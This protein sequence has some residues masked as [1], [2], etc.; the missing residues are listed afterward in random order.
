MKSLSSCFSL[1]LSQPG[2]KCFILSH[3]RRLT[4]CVLSIKQNFVADGHLLLENYENKETGHRGSSYVPSFRLCVALYS[5]NR[6]FGISKTFNSHE[7]SLG[8]CLLTKQILNLSQNCSTIANVNTLFP[9]ISPFSPHQPHNLFELFE[10]PLSFT[11]DE[12]ELDQR[13]KQF[14]KVLHPDNYIG[15]NTNVEVKIVTDL[16][17]AINHAYQV[18][19][20]FEQFCFHLLNFHADIKIPG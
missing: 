5:T 12:K 14:Q 19:C 17:S 6:H 20:C 9:A 18:C 10:F 11:V 2:Q 15:S 13:Y 16:S 3:L 1:I 8:D 7:K 4:C